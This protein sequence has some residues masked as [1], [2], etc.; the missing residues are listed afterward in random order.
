MRC[1]EGRAAD[2][3]CFPSEGSSAELHLP[4]SDAEQLER[5]PTRDAAWKSR[6]AAPPSAEPRGASGQAPHES[7]RR[8]A[9]VQRAACVE[10]VSW[11]YPRRAVVRVSWLSCKWR[12]DTLRLKRPERLRDTRRPKIEGHERRLATSLLS[13]RAASHIA[14]AGSEANA[15]DGARS[16]GLTRLLGHKLRLK[17]ASG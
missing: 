2:A 11:R 14:L 16:E 9:R 4:P 8:G 17:R 7:C 1:P 13:E 6:P 3:P 10:W 12:D 5:H 15:A